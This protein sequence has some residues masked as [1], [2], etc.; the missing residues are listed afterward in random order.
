[1]FQ[2]APLGGRIG[3][4]GK[5]ALLVQLRELVQL[6]YPRCPVIRA[7]GR[8]RRRGRGGGRGWLGRH[9][10]TR[11]GRSLELLAF[12]VH[13]EL[14]PEPLGLRHVP[15]LGEPARAERRRRGGHRTHVTQLGVADRKAPAAHGTDQVVLRP[16]R[17]DRNEVQAH[18]L[19]RPDV[20]KEHLVMTVRAHARRDL[21][22]IFR[23][24]PAETENHHHEAMEAETPGAAVHP[25][26]VI[27]GGVS[28]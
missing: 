10:S 6:R 2:D 25:R 23:A 7:P 9:G 4:V 8:G 26:Q 1:M 27:T 16:V 18:R 13:S 12:G 24:A 22:V 14:T 21:A 19:L 11:A 20:V 15:G 17:Y 28:R 5:R 3:S